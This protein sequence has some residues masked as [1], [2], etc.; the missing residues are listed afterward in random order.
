MSG[1]NKWASIKHKKGA[2]DAKRGKIFT[3]LIR[4]ITVA[5]KLAGGDP[6]LNPRL[7]T[8]IAKAK[9]ANMPNDNIDK[10]I[11]KGTGELEGSSYEEKLYEG[12]GPYGIALIIE[13]LT[14]NTNRT[15]AEIRKILTRGGGN[16][17][18]K[19]CVSYMFDRKGVIYIPKT[20]K[21]NADYIMEIAMD[22]G[23]EDI[24]ATDTQHIIYT[25]MEDFGAVRDFCEEKEIKID[26]SGLEYIANTN[27]QLSNENGEKILNLMENLEDSDDVQN[28]YANVDIE[29]D[30]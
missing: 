4:E 24:Q 23:A 19:G 3:K 2:A 14:D 30:S 11:K 27:V 6:T 26:T 7:R 1:H 21:Y 16:L 17:G 13:T 8:A 12:Y 10:A 18:E 9:E 28:V 25:T 5:A 29:G 15:T 20:E 22:A